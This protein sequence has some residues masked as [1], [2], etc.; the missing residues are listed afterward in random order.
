M[1]KKYQSPSTEAQEY[2]LLNQIC[3]SSEAMW[4]GGGGADLPED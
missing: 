2:E 4:P 3:G 1:K